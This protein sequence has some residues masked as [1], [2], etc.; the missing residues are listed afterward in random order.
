MS[1]D[2]LSQVKLYSEG[3]V[4]GLPQTSLLLL[5]GHT[6]RLHDVGSSGQPPVEAVHERHATV[7][8]LRGVIPGHYPGVYATQVT[9]R[10]LPLLVLPHDPLQRGILGSCTAFCVLFHTFNDIWEFTTK[11]SALLS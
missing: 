1:I 3:D 11:L 7:G 5:T 10:L 8:Q 4:L 6:E 2:V 9:G